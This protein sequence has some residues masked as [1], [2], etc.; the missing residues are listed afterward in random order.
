MVEYFPGTQETHPQPTKAGSYRADK[1]GAQR[2]L[3]LQKNPRRTLVPS[4]V[5]SLRPWVLFPPFSACLWLQGAGLYR[6]YGLI[7]QGLSSWLPRGWRV[8]HPGRSEEG[9]ESQCLSRWSCLPT[10]IFYPLALPTEPFTLCIPRQ[11]QFHKCTP[12]KQVLLSHSG[13][14]D[15]CSQLDSKSSCR[16]ELS[17]QEAFTGPMGPPLPTAVPRSSGMPIRTESGPGQ[18]LSQPDSS[19]RIRIQHPASSIQQPATSSRQ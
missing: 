13:L 3:A 9:G 12:H 7:F 14:R 11:L 10:L 16:W 18:G 4:W 15:L 17:S 6:L 19:N 8:E 1:T 2:G 5:T